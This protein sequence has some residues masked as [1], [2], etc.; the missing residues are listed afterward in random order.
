VRV[1]GPVS[2]PEYRALLRRAQVVAVP[3]VDLAYPTG[4]SVALESASTGCCVVVSGTR[5]MRDLFTDGAT[6][7]LVDVGDVEGWRRVLT[8]LAADEPQRV[9]L[10]GG[11]RRSVEQ[12][13]NADH[14]WTEVAEEMAA[15]GLV[16]R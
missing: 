6:G 5:S 12:R 7:R 13:F 8:E 4:S 10:G 11:A 2:L 3:T 1:Q 15:R 9:N 16:G 14:M